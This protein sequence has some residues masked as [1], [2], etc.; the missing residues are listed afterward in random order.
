MHLSRNMFTVVR[1]YICLKHN[2]LLCIGFISESPFHP[3]HGKQMQT[4]TKSPTVTQIRSETAIDGIGYN[5]L[6]TYL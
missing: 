6:S 2:V 1:N 4:I 3:N 5:P